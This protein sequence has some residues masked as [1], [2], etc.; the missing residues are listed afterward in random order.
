MAEIFEKAWPLVY[1]SFQG[2]RD[3]VNS[4]VGEQVRWVLESLV[5]ANC[6]APY[7]QATE[8]PDEIELFWMVERPS[9]PGYFDV[10]IQCLL[11]AEEIVV[12][13]SASTPVVFRLPQGR[14]PAADFLRREIRNAGLLTAPASP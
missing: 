2:L 12:S 3:R 11:G 7:L 9:A 4:A 6:R 13:P 5:V 8:M 14:Q 10:P 1:D